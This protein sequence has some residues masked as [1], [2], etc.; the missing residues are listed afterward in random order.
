MAGVS[1]NNILSFFFH[2]WFK[3]QQKPGIDDPKAIIQ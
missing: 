3:Q 2:F 1:G